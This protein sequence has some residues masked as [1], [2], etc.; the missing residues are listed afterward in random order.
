[1]SASE[2]QQQVVPVALHLRRTVPPPAEAIIGKD[3]LELITAAM[4]VDPL[5]IYR[6]YIQNAADSIDDGHDRGLWSDTETPKVEVTLEPL[7]RTVRI[8]DNGISVDQADAAKRLLAIGASPKRGTDRRGFRGIGRLAGLGYCQEL[9]FRGRTGVESDVFEVKWD[10]RALREALRA[11]SGIDDLATT[12]K[13]I[14]EVSRSSGTAWPSRFFEVELRK[15]I[16]IRNDILL[17][18]EVVAGYLAQ[19]APVPFNQGFQFAPTITQFLQ[20]H[21]IRAP[22]SIS[23][24]GGAPLCRPFVSTF[25]VTKAVTDHFKSVQFIQ[26][27]SINGGNDA[28]GWVLDHSY[29]GAIPK[30]L[31][32]GGIRLR[33]GDIQ[34]G[35]ADILSENF[36]EPR[37]NNWVVGEFHIVSPKI[38][39]NG[40]RDNFEQ[41]AHLANFQSHV[42]R[43]ANEWTRLCR[44]RSESRRLSKGLKESI[45]KYE[46]NLPII[47]SIPQ[48]LPIREN[49]LTSLDAD[50]R[51]CA[52]RLGRIE[53]DEDHLEM[54]KRLD[55]LAQAIERARS[56]SARA[57]VFDRLPAPERKV[58]SKVLVDIYKAIPDLSRAND[59]ALYLLR[60]AAQRGTRQRRPG[61]TPKKR[62]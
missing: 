43:F 17:N 8:R 46:T 53:P 28:V 59:T 51:K 3:I 19:V 27:P 30:S 61:T 47:R 38:I 21:A 22:L 50:I 42:S 31:G 62:R 20:A 13:Q 58:Y 2:L 45:S 10:A 33:S 57:S 14:V 7:S 56:S 25:Q 34:V 60:R 9:V 15:V 6:E 36:V 49:Q 39:P 37:F 44:S 18:P 41:N 55:A 16:R 11:G 52:R 40:R 23:V 35:G 26:I 48:Q 1:M 5:S 12:I 54:R 32:I 4:Y 24:N 29:Y